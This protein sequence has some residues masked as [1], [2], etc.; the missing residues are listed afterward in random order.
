MHFLVFAFSE[1]KE[2]LKPELLELIRQQRLNRLCHG[3]LFRKISSRRRQG[4]TPRSSQTPEK[5]YQEL[6]SGVVVICLFQTSCGIVGSLLITKSC[7]MEMWKRGR[8]CPPLRLS[9]KRVSGTALEWALFWVGDRWPWSNKSFHFDI[10]SVPVADIK[11]VI[12]GK[13]CPHM[14]ENKGKQAKVWC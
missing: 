7:T 4:E 9:R 13:D 10:P 5:Y 6:L 2:R 8:R 12:T 11:N 14:K 1:L 3:T